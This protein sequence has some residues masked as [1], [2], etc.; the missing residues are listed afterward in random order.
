MHLESF[1]PATQLEAS[2]GEIKKSLNLAETDGLCSHT[3][4][5]EIP[6]SLCFAFRRANGSMSRKDNRKELR[7]WAQSSLN[8]MEIFPQKPTESNDSNIIRITLCMWPRTMLVAL[9]TRMKFSA[10]SLLSEDRN[11]L[12]PDDLPSPLP[13]YTALVLHL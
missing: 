8:C 5:A 9:L 3:C 2:I 13:G 1:Y 11:Q 10:N 6:P 7:E 4:Y 12:L